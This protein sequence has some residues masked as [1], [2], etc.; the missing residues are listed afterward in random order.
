MV[1][2]YNKKKI[3]TIITSIF[4]NWIE[5]TTSSEMLDRVTKYFI[6]L[7]MILVLFEVF[8]SRDK[9]S[10][11]ELTRNTTAEFFKIVESQEF[12]KLVT[13]STVSPSLACYNRYGSSLIDRVQIVQS[14][15][16]KEKVD[17]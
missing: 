1:D 11:M 5:N 15:S 9:H 10:T 8:I 17:Q 16:N 13:C 12:K 2:K 6:P 14:R 4:Q 3:I 7:V